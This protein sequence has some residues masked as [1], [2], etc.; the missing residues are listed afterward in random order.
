MRNFAENNGCCTACI[1]HREL[2]PA[3][4]VHARLLS[5]PHD[6]STPSASKSANCAP[7]RRRR[8]A[9]K[10]ERA[11]RQGTT[12]RSTPTASMRAGVS[13]IAAYATATCAGKQIPSASVIRGDR[14]GEP[15]HAHRQHAGRRIVHCGK[16]HRHLGGRTYIVSSS[17]MGRRGQKERFST[18][19]VSAAA[20]PPTVATTA[21]P[22]ARC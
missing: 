17:V 10:N 21:L 8:R 20:R 1:P 4:R 14:A 2:S 7:H 16:R 22:F 11:P 3:A 6:G 18:T 15:Q 5:S 9:E 13:C 19:A 12:P